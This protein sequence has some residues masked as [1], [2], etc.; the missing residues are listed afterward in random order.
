MMEQVHLSDMTLDLDT[1][2]ITPS[3]D[4]QGSA[5]GY[6]PLKGTSKNPLIYNVFHPMGMESIEISQHG[7]F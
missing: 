6:N 7:P 3:G 4:Q 5:K 1:T 2:V